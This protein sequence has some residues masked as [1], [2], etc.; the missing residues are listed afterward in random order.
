MGHH[1]HRNRFPGRGRHRI[2]DADG[3]GPADRRREREP[4]RLE[5]RIGRP[6]VERHL[7]GVPRDDVAPVQR[8]GA[9]TE[10]TAAAPLGYRAFS[11]APIPPSLICVLS[12]QYLYVWLFDAVLPDE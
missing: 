2:C 8:E 9:A 4:Q 11:L 7:E 6:R 1:R 12:A 5:V 10:H 3:C